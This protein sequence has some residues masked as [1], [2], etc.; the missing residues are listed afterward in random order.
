MAIFLWL[1]GYQR[2]LA[3]QKLFDRRAFER[4]LNVDL[5]GAAFDDF[6]ADSAV[7]ASS[8]NVLESADAR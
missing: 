2:L 7:V 3:A 6:T 8:V 1:A 4:E 5:S